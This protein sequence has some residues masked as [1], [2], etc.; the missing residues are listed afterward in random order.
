MNVNCKYIVYFLNQNSE[1]IR[2][3]FFP[4]NCEIKTGMPAID[5]LKIWFFVCAS[6]R[7]NIKISFTY[8]RYR[9]G[10]NQ[11]GQSFNQFDY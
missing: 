9:T 7:N 6:D 2:K 5:K 8:L 3:G 1:K 11:T 10:L 4:F